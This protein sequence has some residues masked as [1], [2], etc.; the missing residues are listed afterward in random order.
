M[1]AL[2]PLEFQALFFFPAEDGIRDNHVTGVQTCALP[3]LATAAP[4]LTTTAKRPHAWAYDH[5]RVGD[6]K[7]VVEGKSVERGGRRSIKKKKKKKTEH[8]EDIVKTE[9]PS[10]RL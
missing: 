9:V 1:W 2:S 8:K 10:L 4:H 7:S 6:Q 5:D 3:I